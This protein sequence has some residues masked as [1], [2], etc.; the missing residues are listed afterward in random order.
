MYDNRYVINENFAIINA[1]HPHLAARGYLTHILIYLANVGHIAVI[2]QIQLKH[3]V[4]LHVEGL[5]AHFQL[6][7]YVLDAV[8]CAESDAVACGL[9]QLVV[10]EREGQ[11]A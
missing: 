11:R 3:Q 5:V 10:A 1:G 7:G 2:G 4:A 8:A 6:E 9:C